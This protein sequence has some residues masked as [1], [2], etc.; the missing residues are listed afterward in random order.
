LQTRFARLVICQHF[1]A[2]SASPSSWH[3][4]ENEKI[5]DKSDKE[6]CGFKSTENSLERVIN[7]YYFRFSWVIN[8]PAEPQ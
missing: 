7:I 6:M 1:A 8:S 3:N 4:E 2:S 5:I